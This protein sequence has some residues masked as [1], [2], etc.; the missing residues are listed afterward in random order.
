LKEDKLPIKSND[1]IVPIP[2]INI[3]NAL[4]EIEPALSDP[5]NAAYKNPQ[6]RRPFNMPSKKSPLTVLSFQ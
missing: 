2:K 4:P 6:G 5:R 3:H 1:G